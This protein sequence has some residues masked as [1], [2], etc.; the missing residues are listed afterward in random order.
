[1]VGLYENIGKI[2]Q[3]TIGTP[4]MHFLFMNLILFL[5]IRKKKLSLL[6]IIFTAAEKK[7]NK[8]AALQEVL[9]DLKNRRLMNFRNA[10]YT[11]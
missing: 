5:I 2:P 11:L 8:K 10:I 7:R 4:D 9:A 1:M 6:K 3:D